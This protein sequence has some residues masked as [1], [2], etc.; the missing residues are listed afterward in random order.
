MFLS[1]Q[2]PAMKNLTLYVFVVVFLNS[3]AIFPYY[4]T[5]YRLDE[6]SGQHNT[7]VIGPQQLV[8]SGGVY[9]YAKNMPHIHLDSGYVEMDNNYGPLN[10]SFNNPNV[11]APKRFEV[12]PGLGYANIVWEKAGS[13]DTEHQSYIIKGGAINVDQGN[14][15]VNVRAGFG[16]E[17]PKLL[18]N[19][20]F[21]LGLDVDYSYK[22]QGYVDGYGGWEGGADSGS[23]NLDGE[24]ELHLGYAVNELWQ[25]SSHSTCVFYIPRDI[26][27]SSYDIT[28]S[29]AVSYGR[30]WKTTMGIFASDIAYSQGTGSAKSN[31]FACGSLMNF[32]RNF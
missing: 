1:V 16:W 11:Q 17:K 32:S 12:K 18:I 13:L 22:T 10:Q 14:L 5:S 9:L 6:R 20:M 3:C 28:Q 25:L 8:A 23:T 4:P 7:M 19:W 27:P 31:Y 2:K 26:A 29:V 15:M 21:S 24:M 30:K